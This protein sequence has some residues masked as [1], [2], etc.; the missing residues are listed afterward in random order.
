MNTYKFFQC[1]KNDVRVHSIF[2]KWC[3][4]N[5]KISILTLPPPCPFFRKMVRITICCCC[6]LNPE[7][8]VMMY[9]FSAAIFLI[10]RSFESLHD[11]KIHLLILYLPPFKTKLHQILIINQNVG[12][13]IIKSQDSTKKK[14]KWVPS[15]ECE[16]VSKP[17]SFLVFFLSLSFV[18]FLS[19]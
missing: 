1:S 15:T 5:S 12:I 14:E 8:D 7:K 9:G 6:L 3:S 18:S 16:D 19:P 10:R 17:F 11:I 13:G 4:T 2:D